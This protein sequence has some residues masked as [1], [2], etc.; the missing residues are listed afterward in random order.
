M[1]T[2]KSRLTN[3]GRTTWG[4][5]QVLWKVYVLSAPQMLQT[6]A[7]QK[8]PICD[9]N[10]TKM[11]DVIPGMLQTPCEIRGVFSRMPQ[12]ACKTRGV[13]SRML[14]T[15]RKMSGVTSKTLP[16]R[17]ERKSRS[18]PKC[19]KYQAERGK[20]KHAAKKRKKYNLKSNISQTISFPLWKYQ[21]L[22]RPL[23]LHMFTIYCNMF[24]V[25][26]II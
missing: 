9:K 20:Q 7:L 5:G 8:A 14:Q 19:R 12:T 13:T 6:N 23:C 15:H 26:R 25:S 1:Y 3:R 11:K 16:I 21:L 10:R 18:H 4:H 22:S 17:N 24:G 2:A